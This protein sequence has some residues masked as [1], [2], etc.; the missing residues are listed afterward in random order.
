[1]YMQI[2]AYTH[3]HTYMVPSVLHCVVMLTCTLHNPQSPH[4]NVS[5]CLSTRMSHI[6]T[7]KS[8]TIH[9]A[10]S[11]TC[12]RRCLSIIHTSRQKWLRIRVMMTILHGRTE[13]ASRS[14]TSSLITSSLTIEH[15]RHSLC[16][17]TYGIIDFKEVPHTPKTV[18]SAL[19]FMIT[20]HSERVKAPPKFETD[21][22]YVKDMWLNLMIT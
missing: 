1:M 3:L 4:F 14:T 15:I 13:A 16:W 8:H 18:V 12:T 11:T 2:H 19:P 7:Y 21:R 20:R 6:L 17:N 5:P 22:A 9:R 10:Q